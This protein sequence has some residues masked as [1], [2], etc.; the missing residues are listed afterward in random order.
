MSGP[1]LKAEPLYL[2]AIVLVHL[3]CMAAIVWFST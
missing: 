2:A 1:S 3:A